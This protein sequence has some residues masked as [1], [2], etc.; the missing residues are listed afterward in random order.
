[1]IPHLIHIGAAKTGSTFLQNWFESHPQTIY[2]PGGIAGFPSVKGMALGL[3]PGVGPRR[4]FVTSGE[5]L[6]QPPLRGDLLLRVRSA[7]EIRCAKAQICDGLADLFPNAHVL[8]VTRG[9]AGLLKSQFSQMAR[10]GR[11]FDKADPTAGMRD[12]PQEWSPDVIAAVRQ[13]YDYDWALTLYRERFGDRFFVLPYELLSQ[14]PAAF[15][16][17]LERRFGLD[18]HAPE[19]RRLNASLSAREIGLFPRMT[20]VFEAVPYAPLRS[21]L[22]EAH[23]SAIR[24]GAYGS[25]LPLLE[26]LFRTQ[27]AD[28]RTPDAVL[29]KLRGLA[30]DL[31][32]EPHYAPFAGLY[33]EPET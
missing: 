28:M 22:L 17:V 3:Q 19:N 30:H 14:D 24:R 15:V 29:D 6:Y 18:H 21:R 25:V 16:A 20:R 7:E 27:P 31:V 8:L 33:L 1:M 32:K 2:S 9:F 26:T 4:L 13:T 12:R 10:S 11:S 23:R 5:A